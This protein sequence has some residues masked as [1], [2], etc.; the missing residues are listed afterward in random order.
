[1]DLSGWGPPAPYIPTQPPPTRNRRTRAPPG[2]PP[3]SSW[4]L[5]SR[6]APAH[7]R[8]TSSH[9]TPQP[10]IPILL[11]RLPD[12]YLPPPRSL[13]HQTLKSLAKNWPWHMEFDEGY[14]A[15]LPIRYK[16][17]L[18][19]YITVFFTPPS[20]HPSQNHDQ[21][22]HL[23]RLELETLFLDE[24][25]FPN[26][27]GSAD[28]THL[29]LTAA[30]GPNLTLKSLQNYLDPKY[31]TSKN[32][33]S[34]LAAKAFSPAPL[35]QS[36][37]P[38]SWDD[39][40]PSSSSS[41]ATPAI[42]P[43]TPTLRFPHLTHLSLSH[44]QSPTHAS[45][46]GLISLL[47]YT[48]LLTHLSLAH[49]PAPRLAPNA[50]L[51]TPNSSLDAYRASEW[52]ETLGVLR[53]VGK[54]T[55]CLRWLDLEGCEWVGCGA[56]GA[57]GLGGGGEEGDRERDM[58][59]RGEVDG[60]GGD[61][62]VGSWRGVETVRVGRGWVPM[63]LRERGGRWKE[64][65]RR[66]REAG[67]EG[68]GNVRGWWSVEVEKEKWRLCRELRGWLEREAGVD[69]LEAWVQRGRR[70]KGGK[71]IVFERGWEGEWIRGALN[72]WKMCKIHEA[73]G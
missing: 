65:L 23:S 16:Q 61:V 6:H 53:F 17:A 66:E 21:N 15:T 62:W 40:D 35:P 72:W 39:A 29:D 9:T 59:M 26:A 8:T 25:S 14:L 71:R 1:M 7:L 24:D 51:P 34:Y 57:L 33:R 19:S 49:W 44:P 48:P 3:P 55:L 45:W 18:L 43:S 28:A 30:I 22:P 4:L 32:L 27:T 69:V 50:A 58:H 60:D 64:V 12:I 38:A 41:F 37:V 11:D 2:P 70:A 73:G 10:C 52:N 36:A 67:E 63:S 13:A 31:R 54:Q 5:S 20:P 46:P 42:P 56:L 68:E 47:A